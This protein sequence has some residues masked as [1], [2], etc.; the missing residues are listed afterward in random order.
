MCAP[1]YLLNLRG[2]DIPY[3]PLFKAYLHVGLSDVVL[4]IDSRKVDNEICDYLRSFGV[5]TQ[6]YD[7][8]WTF[9]RER[10]IG[11]SKASRSVS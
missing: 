2:R 1:A 11:K 3:T 4:F 7:D 6:E 5:R 8:I 10:E 9:L